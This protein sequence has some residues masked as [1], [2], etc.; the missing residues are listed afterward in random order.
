MPEHGA[1]AAA[2]L[3]LDPRAPMEEAARQMARAGVPVF[4]CASNGKAPLTSRG[5][6]DA[7]TDVHQIRDWWAQTPHANI[8]APTG[9]PSGAVVVDVDTHPHVDGYTAFARADQ[10]GLVGGWEFLTRS[11]SGGMHA[12]FPATLGLEQRSWQAARAGIDFRGDGG[13]IIVPP[14]S[15]M[16]GTDRVPY[17]VET[18]N[19]GP[20]QT[21]DAQRL[22]D[23]LDPRPEPTTRHNPTVQTR[24]SDASRLASW[25]ARREPGE[26]N[27]GLF[28]AAC[29]L[30]ENGMAA[31]DALD[32]LTAAASQA[33]LGDREISTT[34]R[35]AYRTVNAPA[36]RAAPAGEPVS[37]PPAP[38]QGVASSSPVYRG[39]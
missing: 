20:S 27:A 29:R 32:V 7:T 5:F 3:R 9:A 26:R 16:I 13:Y 24:S 31:P 17:R 28:W 1:L 36:R 2:L 4:P 25:V 21:V 38:R 23:F 22:R 19:P 37:V 39:L 33:G 35:S 30:A 18:V 14:S 11:P 34:V 8:G 10:A 6:R 12:Y 15:R